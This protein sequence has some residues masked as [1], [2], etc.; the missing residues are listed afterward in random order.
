MAFPT[1]TAC[2]AYQDGIWAM[3]M[4]AQHLSEKTFL[5]TRL[6][7]RSKLTVSKKQQQQ[8]KTPDQLPKQSCFA[9][10]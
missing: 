2:F 5:Y 6:F 3:G 10:Q 4:R 9:P 8:K 7:I 1:F